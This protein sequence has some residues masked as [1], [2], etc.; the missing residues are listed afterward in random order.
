MRRASVVRGCAAGSFLI[1][2]LSDNQPLALQYHLREDVVSAGC[3]SGARG[4]QVLRKVIPQLWR[5]DFGD[6]VLLGMG[7][8]V[9]LANVLL[10]RHLNSGRILAT[11][12][13]SISKTPP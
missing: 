1:S 12:E 6:L 13:I 8:D 7:A 3:L 10:I 11:S 2:R 9:S 5:N 4:S